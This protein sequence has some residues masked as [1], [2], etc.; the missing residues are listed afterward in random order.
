MFLAWI[1]VTLNLQLFNFVGTFVSMLLTVTRNVFGVLLMTT[2]I[3]CAFAFPLY[4][5][6][7][8]VPG[9]TYTNIGTSIFSV[10]ASLHGELDYRNF[11]L[12]TLMGE[13]RFS[14]LVFLFLTLATIIMP[15]VVINLLIGLAVGDIARI[16]EEALLS[17]RTIEVRALQAL[18]KRLPLPI[19]RRILLE[20]HKHY[21]NR[22]FVHELTRIARNMWSDFD[23]PLGNE[24]TVP[25]REKTSVSKEYHA[26]L[27]ALEESVAK[28]MVQQTHQQEALSRIEEMLKKILYKQ[29]NT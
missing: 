15:I 11:S 27:L 28:V 29:S 1:A 6:L 9:F 18:D 7:A 4:I 16:Q 3:V 10:L 2:L 19:L 23:D 20:S 8:T 26:K 25:V 22:S 12:L 17:Q 14:V 13:L 5:L 24:Q 21:P